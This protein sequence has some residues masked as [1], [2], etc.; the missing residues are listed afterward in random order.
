MPGEDLN[1][2]LC[3]SGTLLYSYSVVSQMLMTV[4]LKLLTVYSPSFI[5]HFVDGDR[6]PM[7]IDNSCELFDSTLA[8]PPRSGTKLKSG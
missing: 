2:C 8:M 3:V 4:E 5:L 7:S 1:E 6:C